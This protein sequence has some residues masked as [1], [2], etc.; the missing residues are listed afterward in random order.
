MRIFEL[1]TFGITPTDEMYRARWFHGTS[2]KR[3]ADG[4]IQNGL[5]YMP[6]L[7]STKYAVTK[8]FSPM[9]GIYLTKDFGNAVR[10]SFMHGDDSIEGYRETIKTE[11]YGYVFEFNSKDFTTV[12]P[13]EDEIGSFLE[14]LV[15][16]AA[17][18]LPLPVGL[19]N[20]VNA[21]PIKLRSSL[22]KEEVDFSTLA[23]AGKWLL[24]NGRLSSQ[25]LR[26]MISS[27]TRSNIVNYGIMKPIKGW[28]IPK[29]QQ[30]FLPDASGT[31]KTTGGYFEYA[32]KY[33]T[34]IDIPSTSSK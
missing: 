25:Q 20:I 21:M 19:Q 3:A 4:I 31:H 12:T 10:Y 32:K 23:Q 5:K 14:K 11:P 15:K 34:E 13:D 7:V 1:A 9:P 6:E 17:N 24:L 2:E 33:A 26:S 16:R 27:S 18:E 29:P 8:T 28:K 22:S 30:R